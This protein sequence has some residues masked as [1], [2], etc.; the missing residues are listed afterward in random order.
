MAEK[1]CDGIHLFG[2]ATHIGDSSKLV[3]DLHVYVIVAA[4]SDRSQ[5]LGM[6]SACFGDSNRLLVIATTCPGIPTIL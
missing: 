4:V 6:K 5:L 2:I 1:L 3:V